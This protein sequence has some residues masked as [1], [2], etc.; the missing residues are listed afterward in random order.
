MK[1]LSILLALILALSC[2]SFA[3]SAIEANDSV[4]EN[5]AIAPA[6]ETTTA[7][8][9]TTTAATV[10]T[11]APTTTAKET[12]TAAPQIPVLIKVIYSTAHSD[13]SY[14]DSKA[15]TPSNSWDRDS[16]SNWVDYKLVYYFYPQGTTVTGKDIHDLVLST[17]QNNAFNVV[18]NTANK[19]VINGGSKPTMVIDGKEF[20]LNDYVFQGAPL[21]FNNDGIL[22]DVQVDPVKH[23]E[24][25]NSLGSQTITD[26]GGYGFIC[27]AAEND[28]VAEFAQVAASQLGGYQWNG[29]AKANVALVNEIIKGFNASADVVAKELPAAVASNKAAAENGGKA[30]N[31][32]TATSTSPKTGTSAVAGVAIVVLALAT[33]TT[34]VLR[35]K[36]D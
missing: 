7:A 19:D 27:Y 30:V 16:H 20:T 6:A 4:A 35:K 13:G 34:V 11:A 1:K 3:A 17:A 24:W 8:T 36:E 31:G 28:D 21:D 15:E 18:N 9:E 23:P 2:F 14:H 32:T 33:T 10:T 5:A 12:T 26:L 25:S 22:D 29:V